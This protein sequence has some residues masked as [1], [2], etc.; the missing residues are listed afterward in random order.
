[1]LCHGEIKAEFYKFQ[2]WPSTPHIDKVLS[3][4]RESDSFKII[5]Q[6][7]WLDRGFKFFKLYFHVIYKHNLVAYN[8]LTGP[9]LAI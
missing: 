6:A 1:M 2:Y 4:L 7:S 5:H 8:G 3:G 9:T